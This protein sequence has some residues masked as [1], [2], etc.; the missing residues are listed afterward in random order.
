MLITIHPPSC[1]FIFLRALTGAG[2][3][4]QDPYSPPLSPSFDTPLSVY[5]NSANLTLPLGVPVHD[6]PNVDLRNAYPPNLYARWARFISCSF[7]DSIGADE[8][9]EVWGEEGTE[10]REGVLWVA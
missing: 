8:E 5:P 4:A 2:L 7:S 1:L 3:P 9:V 10:R 6:K